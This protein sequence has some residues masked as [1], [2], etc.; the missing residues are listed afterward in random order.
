MLNQISQGDCVKGMN[1]LDGESVDLVFADPPFNIGYEYDSYDDR[2]ASQKYLDWCREWIVAVSRVLKADGS[3]W[4]AIGDEYAAELKVLCTRDVGFHCRSWVIWFYTFGVHCTHKFTRSHAHLFHFVKNPKKFTFNAKDIRV[5]SARQ[6]VYGDKRA[7]DGGRVPDD[8]WMMTPLLPPEVPT[9]DGF[10]LRPQD[11]PERFPGESDTWYYSRVAGTF[12]ERQGFHGCQMPEQL[13]GRIIKASS[14]E[15]DVVLDPFGGSGTTLA[16]AKKLGRQYQGFELSKQY[17]RM[18]K[19]RL[20]SINVGDPLDGPE[21]P[22]LSAPRTKKGRQLKRPTAE[23][24]VSTSPVVARANISLGQVAVA[25]GELMTAVA[26]AFMASHQGYSADRVIADPAL[27]EPFLENCRRLG[28][29]G[30]ERDWNHLL[31]NVRKRGGL[32][33]ID[34]SR[35]TTVRRAMMEP[36]VFASEIAW[37]RVAKDNSDCSL[38]EILCDPTMATRFEDLA[39][40]IAPGRSAF[41]YRWAALAVRKDAKQGESLIGTIGADFAKGDRRRLK[42]SKLPDMSGHYLIL[43]P[44]TRFFVGYSRSF[45]ACPLLEFDRLNSA[46]EAM[47]LHVSRDL[48]SEIG[49]RVF[50]S[51]NSVNSSRTGSDAKLRAARRTMLLD[52]FKPLANAPRTS[53]AA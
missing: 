3:F 38:D 27:N 26:E 34:T 4:L 47:D 10:I 16:V 40:Q 41:E 22:A 39:A 44:G 18:I 32:S 29:P 24:K 7:V 21:N 20:K 31:L 9:K 50:D 52:K 43:A 5:P 49:I 28:L 8:T 14:N 30:S 23:P 25:N 48:E 37:R 1:K 19:K 33:S 2:L 13:L 42:L 51:G 12:K 6:L 35:R 36:F 45:R 53:S 11:I 15:G 17:V 46:F